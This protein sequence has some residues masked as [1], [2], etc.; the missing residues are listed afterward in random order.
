MYP[1]CA[2]PEYA[3]SRF[4]S[5]CASA[6]RLPITIDSAA[7]TH[8]GTRIFAAWSD[9]SAAYANRASTA[10]VPA[11]VATDMNAVTGSGAP[12]YTSGVH[13]WKGTMLSLN[14]SP[15][16]NSPA[17]S[18]SSGVTTAL[19]SAE[20]ATEPVA[21]NISA[22]PYSKNPDA[23]DER[24]RYFSADSRAVPR[25][26]IAHRQY[27]PSESSSSPRNTISRLDAPD[28]SIAPLALHS[29]SAVVP[30]T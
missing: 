25:A 3:S 7:S 24:I 1:T 5:V 11:F 18:A 15:T 4:M 17:P 20:N 6:P 26:E 14:A 22:E 12:S 28:I 9:G 2:M 30:A 10:S 23:I 21:P 8:S 19:A 27:R 13:S 16:M 29:S